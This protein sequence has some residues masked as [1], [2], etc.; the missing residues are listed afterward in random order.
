MDRYPWK[1]TI[2]PSVGWWICATSTVQ[3]VGKM[4]N[5]SESDSKYV[6]DWHLGVCVCVQIIIQDGPLL[7]EMF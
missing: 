5:F 7:D 2:F 4:L 6:K 1:N 3:A